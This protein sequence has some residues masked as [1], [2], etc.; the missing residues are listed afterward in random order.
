MKTLLQVNNLSKYFGGQVIFEGANVALGDQQKIG[1]IGRNGAGKST[2]CR[3]IIGEE[4]AD[5][6]SVDRASDLRLA[7]LEQHDPYKP[8]ECVDEFL[9]RYSGREEW[10]CARVAARFQLKGDYYDGPIES[11][12][13]GYRTRV[14][15]VAMLLQDPNFLIL[16]EPTNFLDL[17]TLLLLEHFLRDFNGGFLIVSHDREFLKR[18]CDHS[19]EV[20]DGELTLYPGDVE[21]YLE[22]KAEQVDLASRHNRNVEAKRRQLQTVVDRFRAKARRA[23]QAKS[24]A[25]QI[26]RLQTIEISQSLHTAAIRIPNVD[27]RKGWAL[28]CQELSIGYPENPVADRINLEVKRGQRVAVL[29]EN[30]QGKTTFLR[31][32]ASDLNLLGGEFDW[33]FQISA[34]YYAQ[35]V[36]SSLP[37]N[38]EILEY[39]RSRAAEGIG[40]QEI[41]NL[42]GSFLFHGDDVRKKIGVL[43]GGERARVCLAG[44]LLMRKPLLLLDE[45][46]NHLDIET[47]EALG[48]ALQ[49]YRG[50]VFFVSHD[51]TFVNLV[52][53]Q[54]VEVKDGAIRHY[55]GT[56]QEY[57]YHLEYM[58]ERDLEGINE[59]KKSINNESDDNGGE[60]DDTS[61]SVSDNKAMY[62]RRKELRSH[63]TKVKTR[64]KK[65]VKTLEKLE[66]EKSEIE[67]WFNDNPTEWS[68]EK[69]E[70]LAELAPLIEKQEEEW[71]IVH[72]EQEEIESELQDL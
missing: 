3:I 34:A 30:G 56:Y 49:K 4:D 54:V 32:I 23:S 45:P 1:V 41:K 36:Y 63:L 52:A 19:L 26:E 7:Y 57:V 15:I 66:G 51:R 5:G 53:T 8:G 31:T 24:K 42:A 72:A 64:L 43:S 33:G 13:G 62:L 38:V 29:G 44:I 9:Q 65:V 69:T 14:K 37:E 20:E 58:A 6:G 25:R 2:L 11:L 27:D 59:P 68:Q 21:S 48:T 70:R 46:T 10:E 12:S 35:H 39:L 50:T 71:L 17:N 18:T 67:K 61:E 16:D 28:R 47:V 60:E 55:P 22:F 40:E